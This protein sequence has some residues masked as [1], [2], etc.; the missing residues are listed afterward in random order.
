MDLSNI[1]NARQ[2]LREL[3]SGIFDDTVENR[4]LFELTLDIE[5]LLN[6]SVI[7]FNKVINK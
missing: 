2:L 6:D 7:E 5:K 4:T 3:Q 1:E